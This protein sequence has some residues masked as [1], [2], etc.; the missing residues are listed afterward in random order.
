MALGGNLYYLCIKHNKYEFK[1]FLHLIW[2]EIEKRQS[3]QWK[4][5]HVFLDIIQTCYGY[6]KKY[7][8]RIVI[9]ELLFYKWNVLLSLR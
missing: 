9:V 6:C 8:L 4:F 7:K 3:E 2:N 1:K 5:S